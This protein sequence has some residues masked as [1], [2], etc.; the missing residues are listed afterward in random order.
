MRLCPRCGAFARRTGKLCR[1]GAMPNGRCRMHGGRTPTGERHRAFICGEFTR[2]AIAERRQA[3]E[4]QKQAMDLLLGAFR[5]KTD[6]A[7]RLRRGALRPREVQV[8]IEAIEAQLDAALAMRRP[9]LRSNMLGSI[10]TTAGARTESARGAA[11]RRAVNAKIALVLGMARPASGRSDRSA[12]RRS[13]WQHRRPL[14]MNSEA[15]AALAAPSP[16]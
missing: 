11:L 10:A 7:Q 15:T 13:R 8:Q 6:I 4:L 12:A 16:Q 3:A 14:A 1:N 9:A 2:E 5:A